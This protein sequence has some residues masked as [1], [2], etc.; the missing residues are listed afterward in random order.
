MSACLTFTASIHA[1]CSGWKSSDKGTSRL[2]RN[3]SESPYVSCANKNRAEVF[4]ESWQGR[5]SV[6]FLRC[7]LADPVLF[8]IPGDRRSDLHHAIGICVFFD[9]FLSSTR[10]MVRQAH[11]VSTVQH[12]TCYAA[13]SRASQNGPRNVSPINLSL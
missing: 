8:Q 9:Y 10:L 13:L 5:A 1:T 6:H 2:D 7:K 12:S 11:Q 4:A 3:R